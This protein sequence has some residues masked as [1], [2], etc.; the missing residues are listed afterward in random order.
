VNEVQAI[1]SLDSS[2]RNADQ[3]QI[4]RFWLEAAANS[5]NAI[6]RQ[7]AAPIGLD[8]WRSARLFALINMAM[9]DAYITSF[10]TKYYYHF[11][12]PI[13]AIRLADTDG[14]PVTTADANWL[15]L[16]ETPPMPDYPSAHATVGGAPAHIMR[17]FFARDDLPFSHTSS[18]SGATRSYESFSEAAEE[19]GLS[20]IYVGY[21]FRTA[22][23]HG[24]NQG[25]QIG[26]FVFEH[27]LR[28]VK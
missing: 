11:W 28:P 16:A 23:R 4:A 10:E 17:L 20:R 8:L 5:W 9:A 12:R 15:P 27:A 25:R 21:H 24:L 22:V 1:G 18:I 14:N 19:N 7:V 26:Q 3:T 2:I 13:T 6:A